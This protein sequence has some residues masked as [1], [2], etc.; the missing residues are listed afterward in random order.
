MATEFLGY[1]NRFGRIYTC[2]IQ[3]H[4]GNHKTTTK[5][6]PIYSVNKQSG[7][8]LTKWGKNPFP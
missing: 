2:G 1:S 8:K 3:E 6:Q 7:I 4:N 5:I